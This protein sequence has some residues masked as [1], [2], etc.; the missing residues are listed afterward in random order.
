MPKVKSTFQLR[1]KGDED[2]FILQISQ[3]FFSQVIEFEPEIE[4]MEKAWNGNKVNSVVTFQNNSMTHTQQ[5][6]E[7][8]L[9]IVRNFFDDEMVEMTKFGDIECTAW[10]TTVC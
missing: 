7:K 6:T 4:F 8:P 2:I 1:K 10:Y 9:T 5:H 3:K